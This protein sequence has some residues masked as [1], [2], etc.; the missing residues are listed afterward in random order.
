[1]CRGHVAGSIARMLWG[2]AMSEKTAEMKQCRKCYT[3]KPKHIKYFKSAG[4]GKLRSI[5]KECYNKKARDT[6]IKSKTRPKIGFS[7]PGTKSKRCRACRTTL[8]DTPDYFMIRYEKFGLHYRNECKW[9]Y[10]ER[11]AG[12]QANVRSMRNQ[13]N[14]NR[15]YAILKHKCKKGKWNLALSKEV[16]GD[17]LYNNKFK[18]VYCGSDIGDCGIGLDRVDTEKYEYSLS[19]VL[20]CCGRCNE[21]KGGTT[22]KMMKI[23]LEFLGYKITAPTTTKE[24]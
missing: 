15:R 3:F 4:N 22:T 23:A 5:C 7:L 9:C 14:I 19:N 13:R 20:V 16:Y 11:M 18:C 12:Y 17:L 8:P 21:N 24:E 1:M 10:N 2:C 6:R